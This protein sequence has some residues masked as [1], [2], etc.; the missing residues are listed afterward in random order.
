MFS[1]DYC[2]LSLTPKRLRQ[3]WTYKCRV[4]GTSPSQWELQPTGAEGHGAISGPV[5]Q[6]SRSSS[7]CGEEGLQ[8]CQDILHVARV[9]QDPNRGIQN[10]VRRN[11]FSDR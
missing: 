3:P 5:K 2:I 6:N 11:G 10:D 7:S 1:Y 4:D 8:V 9:V